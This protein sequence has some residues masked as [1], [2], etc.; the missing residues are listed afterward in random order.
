MSKPHAAVM[1]PH[2]NLQLSALVPDTPDMYSDGPR[3]AKLACDLVL[4]Q[5]QSQC[6]YALSQ[7]MLLA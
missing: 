5:V 4:A 7:H 6:A 3:G 1:P 2:C